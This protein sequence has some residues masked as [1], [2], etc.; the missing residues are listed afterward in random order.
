[1]ADVNELCFAAL[2]FYKPEEYGI[3]IDLER[4]TDM[5]IKEAKLEAHE[6]LKSFL[7][8]CTGVLSMRFG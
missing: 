4:Y 2:Q 8:T 6:N 7:S 5:E 1:M 3:G